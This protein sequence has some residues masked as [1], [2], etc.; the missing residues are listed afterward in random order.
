M[1]CAFGAV[2]GALVFT[3]NVFADVPSDELGAMLRRAVGDLME[4]GPPA[5]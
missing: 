3:G 2:M 4:P 5:G 1:A